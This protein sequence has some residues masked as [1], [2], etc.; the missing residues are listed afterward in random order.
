MHR[1]F[2]PSF[3]DAVF[4]CLLVARAANTLP[5]P[6][7]VRELWIE[8]F[9]FVA[10]SPKWF[11][12]DGVLGGSLLQAHVQPEDPLPVAPR[13]NGVYMCSIL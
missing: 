2:P 1:K 4:T 9:Q 3:Q 7:L 13:S 8:I 11:D 6:A 10:A 12:I 5:Y